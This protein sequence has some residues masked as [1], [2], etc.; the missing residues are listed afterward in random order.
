VPPFGRFNAC[1]VSSEQCFR[2]FCRT[3]TEPSKH[4]SFKQVVAF[5]LKNC[6]LYPSGDPRAA[7][8]PHTRK[9]FGSYR[10]NVGASVA[11]WIGPLPVH[12]KIGGPPQDTH[13]NGIRSTC[14]FHAIVWCRAHGISV[15]VIPYGSALFARYSDHHRQT[16][17]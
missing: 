14:R 16:P 1:S 11:F 4:A 15:Q 8:R 10:G 7:Y 17:R 3:A 13:E 6:S 12:H 5:N 9:Q 2:H